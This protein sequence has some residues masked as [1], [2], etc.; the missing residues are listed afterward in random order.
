MAAEETVAARRH[1]VVFA[2]SREVYWP[3]AAS[4]AT[5]FA[6]LHKSGGGENF[7]NIK[8]IRPVLLVHLKNAATIR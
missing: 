6:K 2:S 7:Y 8:D 5:R 1:A 3:G 4:Q